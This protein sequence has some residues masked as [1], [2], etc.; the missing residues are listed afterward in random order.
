M[1]TTLMTMAQA[2]IR[3]LDNQYV[4]L[5]GDETKFVDGV[6]TIFG[7]GNVC[8]LGQALD[9]APGKLAYYQGKSEQGMAHVATAYARQR[10]RR[11]IIAV[12]SSIGPGA[13][14]M[15]TS[16]GC[17]S[18]N[19]VPLLLLPGDAFAT[20][21][22][23]PVLQQVE[24]PAS[25]AI[26]TN[27]AF[28]PVC[29]YWDR[30]QR[31]EQL[32]TAMI[33]AMRVLTDPVETGAVCICI[34]QDVQGES[35][36]YPDY[37]FQKRVHRIPRALPSE[38]EMQDVVEAILAS[39]KPMIIC[40]GG[41]KYSEAGEALRLFCADFGIPFGETQAGKSAI[42]ASDPYYLGGMG[43]TGNIAANTI[44]AEA[45]CIIAVGSRLS[46]FTTSSKW[47][48]RNPSVK[49]VSIN[50]SR[51]HAFKMDSVKAVGDAR[52]TLEA[53]SVHLKARN[54][55]SSYT[56]EIAAAR[57]AWEAEM[58][59]L[60]DYR[61][62]SGFSPLVTAGNP[63]SIEEFAGQTGSRL[64][65]T[66]AICAIRREIAHD[67]IIIGA[68]G[69]LPGDL[70]RMWTTETKDAYHMEY[71]YSCM[72]Y[73]ISGALGIKLAEPEREVYAM[74]GD[75][76]FYMLHS[77]FITA[78]QEGLKINILL[79]DNASNG[80]INNLQMGNGIGNLG[81]E[82][83]R[84]GEDGNLSGP[85]LNT[86]FAKIAE[87]YG[88]KAYTVRT[89]DELVDALADSKKQPGCTLMDM[90]VLP[91][92][93]TPDYLSWWHVGVAS[94]SASETVHAAYEDRMAHVRAA[95]EY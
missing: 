51:F 46:D 62:D 2:L 19:N 5:D 94:V 15:V 86:D 4:S 42:P 14:N 64:T 36:A 27:D 67:A 78:I 73:E 25:L 88:A 93:M 30:I 38:D 12:S 54:Y 52:R 43:V 35:Y 45:D 61:Y 83:R 81:T 34:P 28:K 13:A 72:G 44:A 55:R 48:F 22:P 75:G 90:K 79:F 92:T 57:D 26:T 33:N 59:R 20:R 17:A 6:M 85:F 76:S 7:H 84:R 74:V 9:E 47:L 39:K 41:V 50:A 40:G 60:G 66:G 37:F 87:G 18:V 65:Q 82:F 89:L 23:D 53:L 32:M 69:S 71:G 3:F 8:G 56:G 16:A 77:E 10:N 24:Q 1:K 58:R 91:K 95:R 29:K 31:P 49:M 68:A 11:K 21:Q 70:Q 80:C 63:G